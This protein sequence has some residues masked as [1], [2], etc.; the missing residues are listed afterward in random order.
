MNLSMCKR[1]IY[2]IL[3]VYLQKNKF[4]KNDAINLKFEQG[5]ERKM[6]NFVE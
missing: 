1:L 3:E 4:V 5:R 2:N 6:T